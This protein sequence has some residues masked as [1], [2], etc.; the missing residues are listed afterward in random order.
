VALW[1]TW[2][3]W[4][5]PENRAKSGCGEARMLKYVCVLTTNPRTLIGPGGALCMA[6]AV[7]S[8]VVVYC[9]GVVEVRTKGLTPGAGVKTYP[10]FPTHLV[11]GILS[12]G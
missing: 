2:D 4:V 12:E 1:C 8:Q 7:S 11:I 6:S 9:P 5:L 10:V 3:E